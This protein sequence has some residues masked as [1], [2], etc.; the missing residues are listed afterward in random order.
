MGGGK[1]IETC[2]TDGVT[3]H[4]SRFKMYLARITFN[5]LPE[6][7]TR[8]VHFH[9]RVAICI[10]SERGTVRLSTGLGLRGG[11]LG[12]SSSFKRRWHL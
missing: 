6:E 1:L 5:L 7:V 4:L 12:M 10:S 8:V 11:R 2:A 3:E 9:A